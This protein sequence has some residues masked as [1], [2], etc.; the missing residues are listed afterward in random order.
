[1]IQ[2]VLLILFLV[3]AGSVWHILTVR[4]VSVMIEPTPERLSISGRWPGLRIGQNHLLRPGNYLLKAQKQG[5]RDL[6]TTLFVG[7]EKNQE[8]RLTMEKLPGRLVVTAHDA[9]QGDRA[10]VG[11]EVLLDGRPVGITPATVSDALPGLRRL[12]VKG[13]RYKPLEVDVEVHG[14][15]TLQNLDLPLVPGWAGVRI[16]SIPEG[17]KVFLDGKGVG[18]TPLFLDLVEGSYSL[19]VVMDRYKPATVP[20]QVK[21]NQPL[22]LEPIRLIPAEGFL[23]LRTD[24]SGAAV[25]LRGE[26]AGKTPVEISLAPDEKHPLRVS[27]PGYEDLLREFSLAPGERKEVPLIMTPRKGVVHFKVDPPDALLLI[28]GKPFGV[29]PK[30]LELLAV[31]QDLEIKKEGYESFLTRITPR[32]GFPQELLVALKKSPPPQERLPGE[33]KTTG[34]YTLRLIRPSAYTMGSSRRDQGRRSNET[35]R[36]IVL[37]RS[38][39]M[40]VREVT[41]KEF[42]AAFPDHDSGSLN[43]HSLNKDDQPVVRVS[44]EQAALFCNWLSARE[45]L[46]PV[47][48]KRGDRL[49]ASDPLGPGYRLPTEAEWEYCARLG[50][51][52]TFQKFPWGEAFP[53]EPGSANIADLSSKDLIGD[54]VEAY[55]DGYP[56]SAAPGSFRPNGSGIHDMAGNVSEWCHDY[57]AI[58]PQEPERTQEDPSGPAEGRHRVVRGSSYKHGSISALRGA[59][60]D[61]SESRREDLGFRVCRYGDDSTSEKR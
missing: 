28:D 30:M 31:E 19:K 9:N 16:H 29:V 24:P 49:V 1:M 18:E 47:Y 53:P 22:T 44:W 32:P 50:A 10:I 58:Y 27:K 5:Y 7:T 11:A 52:G 8:L 17:A 4:Q 25:T 35:L 48:V 46:A 42:R 2:A 21:A 14:M 3:L 34:G 56:V 61:Y 38:F 59:Y 20:L 55:N 45:S 37:R 51:K 39:Y 12:I 23:L 57:Y 36:K 40:G 15:G 43:G 60:R 26:Y 41:N 6:E 33:I 13:E 54:Y